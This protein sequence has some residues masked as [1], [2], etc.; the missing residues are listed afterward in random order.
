MPFQM[1]DY[2][3]SVPG[4]RQLF[5][6]TRVDLHLVVN[7]FMTFA[8]AEWAL[9]RAGFFSA[10]GKLKDEIKIEWDKFAESIASSVKAVPDARLRDAIDYLTG[11][12]PRRHIVN[13]SGEL[14]WIPREPRNHS[15]AVFLVRSITTVR[16]NLFHGGKELSWLMAERDQRLLES[17]LLVLTYC[18]GLNSKV[19][20]A[21]AE[22]APEPAAA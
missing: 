4:A 6:P 20:G 13:A 19:V 16:N 15:D 5:S 3:L 9:K 17:S 22:L 7:F 1:P 14:D 18:I 21:F 10:R 12:P 11:N 8:R 2:L